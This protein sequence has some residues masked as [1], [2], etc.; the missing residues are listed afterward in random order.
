MSAKAGR[1]G[2]ITLKLKL[3]GSG[4]LVVSEAA[5]IPA[6]KKHAK[7]K[8]ITYAARQSS[9]RHGPAT[10]TIAI[11]PAKAGASALKAAKTLH[12]TV[13]S[14][15]PDRRHSPNAEAGGHRPLNRAAARLLPAGV[16]SR[17][18]GLPERR[19]ARPSQCGALGRWAASAAPRRWAAPAASRPLG[20]ARRAGQPGQLP[21][22][23]RAE[24]QQ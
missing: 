14:R 11:K 20:G 4:R 12:V 7:P 10:V 9:A 22:Y 18:T 17:R 8:T 5:T 13:R 21:I 1:R 15:H 24:L 23:Q 19:E 2:L 16:L 6:K 3:P